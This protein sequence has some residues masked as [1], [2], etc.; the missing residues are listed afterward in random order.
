MSNRI[1]KRKL[2][3]VSQNSDINEIL[4]IQLRLLLDALDVG[5]SLKVTGSPVSDVLLA[6]SDLIEV[7]GQWFTRPK[8]EKKNPDLV[9]DEDFEIESTQ[10]QFDPVSGKWI[11]TNYDPLG[12][13]GQRTIEFEDPILASLSRRDRQVIVDFLDILQ[14]TMIF[15]AKG[16]VDWKVIKTIRS[17]LRS[18]SSRP[19][20]HKSKKQTKKEYFYFRRNLR[21]GNPSKDKNQHLYF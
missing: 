3:F 20:K 5:T 14:Q 9:F 18:N 15:L 19:K 10:S 11:E 4:K 21:Q 8:F 17:F 6:T 16:I 2:S 13:I 7:L 12:N 1:P